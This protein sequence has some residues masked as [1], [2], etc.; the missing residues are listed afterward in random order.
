MGEHLTC[1]RPLARLCA[2][3][4][5]DELLG[6]SAHAPPLRLLEAQVALEQ[7]IERVGVCVDELAVVAVVK[8]KGRRACGVG[9]LRCGL[10]S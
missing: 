7:P 10:T 1:T 4:Q 9:V 5:R 6:A 8:V 2:H 3:R